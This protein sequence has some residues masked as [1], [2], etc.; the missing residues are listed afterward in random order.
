MR[1]FFALMSIGESEFVMAQKDRE[2]CLEND[3]VI[4]MIFFNIRGQKI[5]YGS[6]WVVAG[7]SPGYDKF[8]YLEI[9]DQKVKGRR[10]DS[11]AFI[12]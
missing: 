10:S 12:F 9:R 4:S 3:L 8:H 2:R 7:K 1:L 11:E 5:D 6:K